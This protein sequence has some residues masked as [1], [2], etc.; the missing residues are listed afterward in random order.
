MFSYEKSSLR[1]EFS[2]KI[3]YLVI[4]IAVDEKRAKFGDFRVSEKQVPRA[5]TKT[6]GPES[7]LSW[8]ESLYRCLSS[9]GRGQQAHYRTHN[10]K[11]WVKFGGILGWCL[12]FRSW[13]CRLGAPACE[14]KFQHRSSNPENFIS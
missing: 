6:H 3:A 12:K 14:I 8:I 7:M 13:L 9:T 1:L 5:D 4:F 10:P 2:S 11:V